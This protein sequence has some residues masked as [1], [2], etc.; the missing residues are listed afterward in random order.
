MCARVHPLR[1]LLTVPDIAA[2]VVI[3]VAQGVAISYTSAWAWDLD[4]DQ[5]IK[6]EKKMV[7]RA[8]VSAPSTQHP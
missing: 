7:W 3:V 5:S 8:D 1:L 4:I 2:V 6:S